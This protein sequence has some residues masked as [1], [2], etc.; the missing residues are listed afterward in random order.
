MV[1]IGHSLGGLLIKSVLN[2][3]DLADHI[4]LVITLATPHQGSVLAGL[5]MGRLGR[6]LK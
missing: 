3:P 5:A 4:G 1:L 2:H 6:S